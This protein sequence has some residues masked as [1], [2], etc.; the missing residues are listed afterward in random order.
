MIKND[1]VGA[2][3]RIPVDLALAA[4]NTLFEFVFD[5]PRA[6]AAIYDT[7]ALYHASHN[8]LFVA[9]LSATEFATHR[10]AMAKQTRIG[11]A[12]RRGVTPKTLLVPFDLQEAAFNLFQRNQNLDKTFV[13]SQQPDII[14][15]PYWT[16]ANDWCTVAD[17]MVLPFLEIGFLDGRE[18]PELFTQDM[19][20]VGNL[21]TNDKLTWKIRHI[22]SGAVLPEGEK[23]TTKAVVP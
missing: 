18:E 7:V 2:I 9:A 5:F 3:R 15:V 6:N 13:N 12:K 8:N 20:N 21:F 23:A 11:S 17:P 22:Y 1:D 10:L 4:A 14:V 19:P 16:D